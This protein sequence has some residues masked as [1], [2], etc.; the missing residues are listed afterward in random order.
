M[1]LYYSYKLKVSPLFAYQGLTFRQPNPIFYLA[2]VAATALLACVLPRRIAHA[3]DFVLWV[4]FLMVGAPSIL[5]SQYMTA[6]SPGEACRLGAVVTA[7]LILIRVLTALRPSLGRLG[8]IVFPHYWIL[9]GG[10]SVFIYAYLF[11][12][13]GFRVSWVSLK[14]VYDI[15]ADYATRAASASLLGYLIPIQ[16]NVINP[17]FIVRG[18]YA[19][20]RWLAAVGGF[21][22]FFIYL[23]T[24]QKSVLFS[25]LAIVGLARLFGSSPRMR[26]T[27]LLTATAVAGLVTF[28]A[29]QVLN[30]YIWSSL[31][32]RRFMIVPGA[33]TVAYVQVFKDRPKTNFSDSFAFWLDSPYVDRTPVRIVG[34]QFVG[35]AGTNSNVSIFGHGFLSYGYLGMVVVSL[36]LVGVLWLADLTTRGLPTPVAGLMFFMPTVALASASLFTTML[37][38]GY[39]AALL[40][41]AA[42]PRSGWVAAQPSSS[43]GRGDSSRRFVNDG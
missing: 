7:C 23:A 9:L 16:Y 32:V 29:D 5:M 15:R 43:V 34:E 31:F 21:G 18:I 33:L 40:I 24:G 10:V 4:L 11:L 17:L 26:G 42:A 19:R 36:L 2:S 12:V 38:H 30:S 25:T 14:D 20:A 37:T 22:Q 8:V 28:A 1:F 6:L 35:N 13:L 41:C 27:R 39:I 3:S